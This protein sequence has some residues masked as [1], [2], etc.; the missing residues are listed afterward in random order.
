MRRLPN[1]WPSIVAGPVI[2]CTATF[3]R[4]TGASDANVVRLPMTC[5][6]GPAAQYFTA[7]VSAPAQ[8]T[9]GSTYSIRIDSLPSGD[10]AHVGL[11]YLYDLATDYAIPTGTAYVD[12]SAHI[13]PNS[14]SENVRAGASVWYALGLIHL[15]LP[16]HVH[17]PYTPPSVEFSVRVNAPPT[18]LLALK[19]AQ[20]RLVANVFLLGDLHVTCKPTPES[21]TIATTVVG[22]AEPSK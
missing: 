5:S 6:R 11:N 14:G 20:H 2:A 12:G 18:T 8:A 21:S 22:A 16:A 3:A 13:V 4:V 7:H 15:F 9:P 17:D 1:G 19:F 10:I